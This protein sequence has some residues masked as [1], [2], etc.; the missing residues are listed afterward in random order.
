M[1]VDMRNWS[2]LVFFC[3]CTLMGLS[4]G[5][6]IPVFAQEIGG[7]MVPVNIGEAVNSKYDEIAPRISPDGQYLFFTRDSHPDNTSGI[8]GGQDI[9]Y[10]T[11]HKSG[12]WLPALNIG[13]PLNT[14]GPNSICTITP[15]GNSA[16]LINKYSAS[17]HL[18]GGGASIA[19]R[20]ANGQWGQP[21]PI[22]IDSFYNK[23]QYTSYF[24]TNDGTKL[25]LAIEMDGGNGD[26]DLYISFLKSNNHWST[27]INLGAE[28]NTTTKE[29]GL[30]M[31]SDN[32]TLYFMSDGHPGFGNLDIFMTR[33]LDE[34]WRNWSK[35]INLGPVFNTKGK[36][37]YFSISAL[38]QE[39]YYVSNRSGFGKLDVFKVQLA[40]SL[41]P[42]PVALVSGILRDARN[43]YP[44]AALIAYQSIESPSERGV[45]R[46][47]NN[48]QFK[49]T[50]PLGHR[51]TLRST[52]PNQQ[53]IALD[54]I[55]LR[56]QRKYVEL[57]KNMSLVVEPPKPKIAF[58][59]L[60]FTTSQKGVSEEM[61][62]DL[63][64]IAKTLINN[65][66]LR[67][68]VGGHTDDVGSF[69]QNMTLSYY[70]AQSVYQYLIDKGVPEKQ[71]T[72]QPYGD[73]KPLDDN[74]FEEGRAMNRRV[75]FQIL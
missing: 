49:L 39:A 58:P 43:L 17:G 5:N 32:E 64:E 20:Q 21:T 16:L 11:W 22:V 57:S 54:S 61:K 44:L 38:G 24:L 50:L 75:S 60:L 27:P 36:D 65:P 47:S 34:S 9:W 35:P 28:I 23:N 15:D 69:N 56:S 59:H 74:A 31:A 18:T 29:S 55:D 46:T 72:I 7:E 26:L 1:V 71:M 48:G 13:P 3:L 25:F 40:D 4:I 66:Q 33:R 52:A 68:E 51:Y 8:R 37:G 14:P 73:E 62:P 10:S 2:R 70:R 12:F 45:A 63:D 30:F 67:V 42:K 6:L 41:K 53:L 19:Y